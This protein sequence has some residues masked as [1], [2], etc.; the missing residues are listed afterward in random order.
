MLLKLMILYHNQMFTIVLE[1][2]LLISLE[3]ALVQRSSD[4]LDV[5]ITSGVNARHVFHVLCSKRHR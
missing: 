5:L 3:I 4:L 1:Q 2:P